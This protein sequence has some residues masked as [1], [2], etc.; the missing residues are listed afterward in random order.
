[1]SI[2][3]TLKE[4]AIVIVASPLEVV[5]TPPYFKDFKTLEGAII[6]MVLVWELA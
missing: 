5:I 6:T 4:L 2:S 1:L 3:P